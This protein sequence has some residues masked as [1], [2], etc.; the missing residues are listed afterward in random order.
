MAFIKL[1]NEY[2]HAEA[3]VTKQK[4]AL[5]SANEVMK[6]QRF[7]LDDLQNAMQAKKHDQEAT[8]KVLTSQQQSIAESQLIIDHL[9]VLVHSLRSDKKCLEM[10]VKEYHDALTTVIQRFQ[11]EFGSLQSQLADLNHLS[12]K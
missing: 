2:E 5:E 3:I 7:D 12:L 9:N 11:K 4:Q 6:K 1:Q 8:S 10:E